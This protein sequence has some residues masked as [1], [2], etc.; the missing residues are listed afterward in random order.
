[1]YIFK[2]SIGLFLACIFPACQA[3]PSV[4]VDY[5]G[6]GQSKIADII[7]E[8]WQIAPER[9]LKPKLEKALQ[10]KTAHGAAIDVETAQQLGF[11]CERNLLSCEYRGILSYHLSGVPEENRA[12][13]EKVLVFEIQI[14]E[15]QPLSVRVKIIR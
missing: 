5:Q 4:K 9:Y 3:F 7:I 12:N 2:Q 1:V 10:K 6:L 14:I 8:H 15:M 11:R 13:A